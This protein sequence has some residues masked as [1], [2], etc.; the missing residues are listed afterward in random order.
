MFAFKK[1]PAKIRYE[2]YSGEGE[3]RHLILERDVTVYGYICD[4]QLIAFSCDDTE[5]PI[6]V[7]TL[8][9]DEFEKRFAEYKLVEDEKE[10]QNS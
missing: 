10:N 9:T 5:G 3:D 1:F 6:T 4:G 7:A 2:K 8:P